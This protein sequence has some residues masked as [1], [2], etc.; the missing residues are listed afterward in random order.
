MSSGA[1]FGAS[2]PDGDARAPDP[3]AG[4]AP[5]M[6]LK[7]AN[8]LIVDDDPGMVRVMGRILSGLGTVRFA[9]TGEQALLKLHEQAPDVL[10]LDAEM[11]GMSGFELCASLKADPRIA[12]VPVIFVTGHR[13]P[14]SELRG[15]ELGAVDFIA[16]PVSEPLLL[17]RVRTQ[18]RLKSLTDELR[19]LADVD[20][21][22]GVMNRRSF[23]AALQHEW[24][25]AARSGEPLAL[26]L[27]DVD[28]FK[29]YNDL[30]GHLSGDE[31]L[32]Q[33]AQTLERTL[34]RPADRVARYG[35]EEFAVLLPATHRQGAGHLA[36]R[37]HREL[38]ALALP[39]GASPTSAHVSVSVGIS[40][41]DKAE[42]G[43]NGFDT[44]VNCADLAFYAAK[45]TGRARSCW[46]AASA[47]GTVDQAEAVSAA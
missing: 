43:R 34:N 37:L 10:L 19:R 40:G 38:A 13:D 8:I 25:R 11:P 26:L 45:R 33:V 3:E 12:H 24:L 31:C 23:D 27:V 36:G 41:V 2:F 28:H 42:P 20:G 14:D 39:H 16:K 47:L 5:T 6:S 15:L 4:Y 18:L 17:A 9:T 29:L 44:L 21:L 30:Y 35:G 46:L 32:R 1:M 7:P 22:T